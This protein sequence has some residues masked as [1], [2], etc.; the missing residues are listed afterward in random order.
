MA[1]CVPGALALSGKKRAVFAF[2][3]KRELKL[4]PS[5]EAGGAAP[6]LLPATSLRSAAA[7]PPRALGR[8]LR[9]SGG[10]RDRAVPGRGGRAAVQE[11]MQQDSAP[12]KPL[13]A[14]RELQDPGATS[15][16]GRRELSPICRAPGPA[17]VALGPSWALLSLGC[18][19]C[20]HA[21]GHTVM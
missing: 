9:A 4:F 6:C 1:A 12:A 19:F 13:L 21:R 8:W 16:R 15:G 2:A 20:L 7:R 3:N 17:D 14:A 5:G 11:G 18:A 10:R